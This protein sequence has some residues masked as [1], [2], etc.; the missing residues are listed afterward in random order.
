MK[1][2]H[3]PFAFDAVFSY[4]DAGKLKLKLKR[5]PTIARIFQRIDGRYRYAYV[6]FKQRDP[7]KRR[8][9]PHPERRQ[10]LRIVPQ[11]TK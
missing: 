7:V 1:D 4:E 2:A 5:L 11:P 10:L 8:R 9:Q 6:Q 3:C